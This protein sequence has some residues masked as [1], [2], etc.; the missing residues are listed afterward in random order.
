MD[1]VMGWIRRCGDA[2]EGMNDIEKNFFAGVAFVK[3]CR[4]Y[5]RPDVYIFDQTTGE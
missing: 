1:A 3:H 4:L 2:S 5:L